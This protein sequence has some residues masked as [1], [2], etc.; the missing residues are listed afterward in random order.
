MSYILDALRKSES[1]RR[2]GR[3]PDLGQQV[4][5][6]HKPRKKTSPLVLLVGAGLLLNAAVLAVVF[7]PEPAKAPQPTEPVPAEPAQNSERTPTR[8]ETGEDVQSS[9]EETEPAPIAQES[10]TIIV[11][12]R[13]SSG[14][15]GSRSGQSAEYVVPHISGG[16]VPHLVEMPLTFQKSIPDLV[17]NSHI[18]ASEPSSRRVMINNNYLKVGDSFEGIRVQKITEEGVVLSRNGRSFRV[19]VVRDWVS[20]K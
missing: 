11:P 9:P 7:W 3:V 6:I 18:Y 4:Q 17:F 19:G 5:F 13:T 20:P 14:S 16:P 2:Q 10:P 1:E 12:S 8:P 15:S